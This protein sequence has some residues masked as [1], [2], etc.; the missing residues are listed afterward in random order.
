MP[1]SRRHLP[2]SIYRI[3][4]REGDSM[5][6]LGSSVSS[7]GRWVVV[8]HIGVVTMLQHLAAARKTRSQTRKLTVSV[9]FMLLCVP[10]WPSRDHS[11]AYIDDR[12]SDLLVLS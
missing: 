6:L 10:W 8:W 5:L 11:G 4:F 1:R 7:F 2:T 12:S 9:I 3:E